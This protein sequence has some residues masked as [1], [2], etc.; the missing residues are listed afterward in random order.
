M[1]HFSNYLKQILV[2]RSKCRGV[3]RAQL[4]KGSKKFEGS[5]A[6]L[7]PAPMKSKY[8][9]R[10]IKFGP[11]YWSYIS[12]FSSPVWPFF[13][14]RLKCSYHRLKLYLGVGWAKRFHLWSR[15]EFKAGMW[16]R[17]LESEALWRKKLEAEA[18]SEAFDFLKSRKWKH[19]S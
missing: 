11:K 1:Q 16:K 13:H 8:C 19:F 17:K 3:G 15:I 5:T 10:K 18:N 12:L 7:L 14:H 6:P 9:N 2:I 4:V